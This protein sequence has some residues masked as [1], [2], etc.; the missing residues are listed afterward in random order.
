M[1]FFFFTNDWGKLNPTYYFLKSGRL[2]LFC[3]Q[4]TYLESPWIKIDI[5]YRFKIQRP[6][7][8]G[9][10]GLIANSVYKGDIMTLSSLGQLKH[11]STVQWKCPDSK[12]F[13]VH[14]LNIT[15]V[16]LLEVYSGYYGFLPSQ[17]AKSILG[18]NT[19]PPKQAFNVRPLY[20]LCLYLTN[21]V[22]VSTHPQ[23]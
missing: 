4:D 18:G 5:I 2:P 20:A 6:Q 15:S 11:L 23:F 10:L 8:V 9:E 21:K 1:R 3:S 12:L 16:G 19:F 14:S 17:S 22:K 7:P 13:S